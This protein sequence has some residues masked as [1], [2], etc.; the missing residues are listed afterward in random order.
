MPSPQIQDC[1]ASR[2]VNVKQ[3]APSLEETRQVEYHV[4][5]V[6]FTNLRYSKL[7]HRHNWD[8][9]V[10]PHLPPIKIASSSTFS[11]R[12]A[13]TCK[14]SQTP[15]LDLR[16]LVLYRFE[17]VLVQYH[18]LP[19]EDYQRSNHASHRK[20]PPA[21]SPS[22]AMLRN[23]TKGT[24]IGLIYLIVTLI[25]HIPTLTHHPPLPQAPFLSPNLSTTCLLL[26]SLPSRS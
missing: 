15:T 2:Q 10:C 16:D 11:Q 24:Y 8:L 5:G 3:R 13:N 17:I 4:N 12:L 22:L 23:R 18:S 19:Q 7:L 6:L 20:E 21:S 26:P 25:K 14:H 9:N 1:G